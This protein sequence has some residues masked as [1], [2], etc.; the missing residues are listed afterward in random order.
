MQSIVVVFSRI[1]E[2]EG[3]AGAD[4]CRV[5]FRK[6]GRFVAAFA[7]MRDRPPAFWRMRLRKSRV[8][9]AL[10]LQ[11]PL[12]HLRVVGVQVAGV[13]AVAAGEGE[14]GLCGGRVRL[15]LLGQGELEVAHRGRASL[16]ASSRS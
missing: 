11:H 1:W 6:T 10:A 9:V 13:D 14:R 7:R 15:L 16:I 3:N 12:K 4:W 8:D 5:N 2:R